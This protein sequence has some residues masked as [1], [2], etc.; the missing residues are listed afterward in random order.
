MTE[1][2]KLA[3]PL[4][5]GVKLQIRNPLDAKIQNRMARDILDGMPAFV[6]EV[7]VGKPEDPECHDMTALFLETPDILCPFIFW[8]YDMKTTGNYALRDRLDIVQPMVG[9]TGPCI[10]YVDHVL[11]QTKQELDDYAEKVIKQGFPGVVLREPF[12][13]FGTEDEEVP[14]ESLGLQTQ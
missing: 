2:Y 9:A 1:F 7:V 8:V 13:T 10:Q 6:G 12:G 14:A 3:R 11:V 4:M 5:R